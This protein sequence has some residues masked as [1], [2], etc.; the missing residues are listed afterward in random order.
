MYLNDLATIP[1]NLSGVPGISVPS[2]LADEDGLPAGVQIL[3]PAMRRRP[4]LPRR[5]RARGAARPASGAAAC[6]TRRPCVWQEPGPHDRRP[7]VVRRRRSRGSTR[8]S[9]LEVH[10]ELNT[11]TKMFCGCPTEFGA[12]PNTQTCPTCLGL[13]G[14]DAGGQ[15]QGGGVGDPDRPGAQLRD[16]GV[17]PVRAEELLLPGHAEELPDQPVRR[18]DRVRGL[19]GRRGRRRDLPGRDRARPHGGGHRQVAARRR[20]HRPDP[21]RRLLAGRLQPGRHP[22]DRDRHQAGARH[23]RRRRPRSPGPTSRSCASCCSASA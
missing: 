3:A 6:S 14:L 21:R 20:Q 2:G 12:E 5:R 8:P 22:A 9:G 16:R 19:H 15:R 4:G 13:P 10:V 1:A 11:A 18:A 7:A 17:V 23:R